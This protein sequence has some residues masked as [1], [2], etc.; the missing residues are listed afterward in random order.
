MGACHDANNTREIS[1]RFLR[2]S[3]DTLL[4]LWAIHDVQISQRVWSLD[5][6]FFNM[7]VAPFCWRSAFSSMVAGFVVRFCLFTH[8][9]SLLL[10]YYSCCLFCR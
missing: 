2:C 9:L 5:G 8:F 6:G 1:S 4:N 3:K 7:H 10:Y